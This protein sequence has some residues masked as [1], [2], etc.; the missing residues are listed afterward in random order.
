YQ[1]SVDRDNWYT[2]LRKKLTKFSSENGRADSFIQFLVRDICQPWRQG[3][4]SRK[5]DDEAQTN[6]EK[7]P[8][9]GPKITTE[10]F[11]LYKWSLARVF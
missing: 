5:R 3:Q 1:Q 11:D 9:A 10:C 4:N 8:E 2:N 7:G 6:A